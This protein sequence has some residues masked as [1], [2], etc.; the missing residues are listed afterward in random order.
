MVI[1]PEYVFETLVECMDSG[2]EINSGLSF[3]VWCKKNDSRKIRDTQFWLE[4]PE[5]IKL[6]NSGL[7]E[8]FS[9]D[10]E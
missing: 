7:E 1:I 10:G 5:N 3:L 2:V 9:V 8:G 6:F 4:K